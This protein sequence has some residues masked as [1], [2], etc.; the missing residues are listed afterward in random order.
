MAFFLLVAA[1][2]FF[3]A[4]TYWRTVLV[5]GALGFRVGLLVAPE[6][7]SWGKVTGCDVGSD[8]FKG[9]RTWLIVTKS[10]GS[11]FTVRRSFSANW[12]EICNRM[13]DR[14]KA[15][16]AARPVERSA[17][18]EGGANAAGDS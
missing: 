2:F 5:V 16:W 18:L 4:F 8:Y 11:T 15:Y 17:E 9:N 1:A 12:Y 7:L 6:E 13:D 10:D 14:R 3:V